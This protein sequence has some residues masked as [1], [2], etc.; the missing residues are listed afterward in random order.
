[1]TGATLAGDLRLWETDFLMPGTSVI[2]FRAGR[3]RANNAVVPLS[4]TG[5]LSVFCDMARAPAP[6]TS[7]LDVVG[8]FQ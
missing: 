2:N 8:Y 3:V 1:V 6:P 5:S 4:A 7:S